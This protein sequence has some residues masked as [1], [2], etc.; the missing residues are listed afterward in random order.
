MSIGEYCNREVIVAHRQRS[1]FEISQL[2][3]RHHV[4]DV[5]IVDEQ[6]GGNVPVGIITDR[7]IVLEMIAAQVPLESCVAGDIMSYELVMAR[8]NEGLWEVLQRMRARGVRRIPVVDDRNLL[9]G[10]I[11][12]DDLL[13]LISEEMADLV[14]VVA[15]EQKRERE[16]RD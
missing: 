4:G 2:M 16:T 13:E 12:A 7:D 6:G 5:V 14:R 8:E 11:T 1:I 9:V 3:R 10:L 15:K